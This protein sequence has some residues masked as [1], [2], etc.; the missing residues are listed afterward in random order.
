MSALRAALSRLHGAL[1][2]DGD[3][4]EWRGPPGVLTPGDREVLA[5]AR[6]AIVEAVRVDLA[7]GEVCT[8]QEPG[9]PSQGPPERIT[10][11]PYAGFL[12][13]PADRKPDPVRAAIAVLEAVAWRLE[14]HRCDASRRQAQAKRGGLAAPR[15]RSA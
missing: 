14:T 12:S 7:G 3:T 8:A 4:L 2:A 13:S 11:G 10:E 9:Q 6:P 15:T 5:R 1:Q